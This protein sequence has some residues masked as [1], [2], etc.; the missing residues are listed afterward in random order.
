[1]RL[2]CLCL[3]LVLTSPSVFARGHSSNYC[4][5]CQHTPSGK[6]KRSPEAR[7]EFKK[8]NPCPS[9]GK[10]S[11]TCPGYVIDHIKALKH[12]GADTPYNMQWQTK[13]EAKEK[14]NWE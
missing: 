10:S 5:S 12:G 2:I 8:A 7:K 4:Y 6:I 9:T 1:M 14:D 11:G 3:M 13:E